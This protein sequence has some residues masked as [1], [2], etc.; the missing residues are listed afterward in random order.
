MSVVDELVNVQCKALT[1]CIEIAD[2]YKLDRK[3]VVTD[4]I[5]TL[6]LAKDSDNFYNTIYLDKEEK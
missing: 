5:D 6:Y 4:F 1:E 3:Q 2:K